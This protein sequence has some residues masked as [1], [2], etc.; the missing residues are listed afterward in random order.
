MEGGQRALPQ[1]CVMDTI[2]AG[3]PVPMSQEEAFDYF[4]SVGGPV[5]ME[6]CG[7]IVSTSGEMLGDHDFF[8]EWFKNPNQAE[9]NDL[10]QK[11]DEALAPLG[12]R[13]SITTKR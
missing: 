2:I 9:M 12:C 5:T 7:K 11:I 10:I 4:G 13:Y 8:F 3:I 6:R 1:V